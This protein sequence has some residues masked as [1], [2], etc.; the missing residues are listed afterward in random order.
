MMRQGVSTHQLALHVCVAGFKYI[1]CKTMQCLLA[2]RYHFIMYLSV[3]SVNRYSLASVHCPSS[4]PADKTIKFWTWEVQT[5]PAAPADPTH[6]PV[7]KHKQKHTQDTSGAPA[8][9]ADGPIVHRL[10]FRQTRQLEM[11]ED[12]L[13]VKVSPD[14]RLL[15]ASLLDHTI[16]VYYLDRWVVLV[17]L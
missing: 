11:A 17:Y 7:K 16:K 1:A 4:W 13:C 14:G 10:G 8:A 9:A 3:A 12:V 2:P 15:A 5:V 6:H